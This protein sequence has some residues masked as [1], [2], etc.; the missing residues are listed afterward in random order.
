MSILKSLTLNCPIN[1]NRV[2][3]ITYLP[4]T[5]FFEAA[6]NQ[7]I[8]GYDITVD[9]LSIDAFSSDTCNAGQIR[10]NDTLISPFTITY[11]NTGNSGATTRT[12]YGGG[13]SYT[14]VKMT[15]S[16]TINNVS[17]ISG[18]T[19]S[20]GPY[21]ISIQIDYIDCSLPFN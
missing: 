4:E 6:L 10:F 3:T 19:A 11:P 13:T 18:S 1:Y 7:S 2:L 20:I 15:N 14:R 16:V 12:S 8:S 21:I 17:Y 5:A 9:D